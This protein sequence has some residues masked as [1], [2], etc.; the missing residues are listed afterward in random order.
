METNYFERALQVMNENFGH[1]V[2]MCLASCSDNKLSIRDLH[3]MYIYGKMYVLSKLGNKLMR[4]IAVCPNVAL[5]HG[6]HAMY[7]AAVS[8]GHP[9]EPK[10]AELRKRLKREFNLDYNEYVDETNP[11]MRIVEITL[12]SAQT[13]TRFHH[14]EIDFVSKTATRDHSQPTFLY[15]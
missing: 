15:R 3:A 13:Y 5:C 1:M 6:P 9:C 7:G 2:E 11:D 14:Y 10:N 8:V 12:T 4:D